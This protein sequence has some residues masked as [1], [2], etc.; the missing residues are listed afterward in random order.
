[1]KNR[2][3]QI[4]VVRLHDVTGAF[5][6]RMDPNSELKQYP[7]IV[8]CV[9]RGMSLGFLDLLERELRQSL[10]VRN[11]PVMVVVDPTVTIKPSL[12]QILSNLQSKSRV[13]VDAAQGVLT[14]R[15]EL[16]DQSGEG[17]MS[18]E[19]VV[20]GVYPEVDFHQLEAY[21][22][23]LSPSLRDSV[24]F[25]W[26]FYEDGCWPTDGKDM[27]VIRYNR[28]ID[29]DDVEQILAGAR[30]D[31]TPVFVYDKNGD[32][33]TNSPRCLQGL[34]TFMSPFEGFEKLVMNFL[35]VRQLQKV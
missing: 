34:S 21:K 24:V 13:A 6:V 35:A 4:A 27:I 23:K 32:L 9:E 28:M 1:M 17:R 19:M 22:Q 26:L 14:L 20:V 8:F 12:Q 31:G 10:E 18:T 16:S 25:A 7:A 5:A 15:Q 3:N 33:T 2:K 29:L 30:Q 11:Q